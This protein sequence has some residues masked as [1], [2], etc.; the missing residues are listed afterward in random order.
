MITLPFQRKKREKDYRRK[1]KAQRAQVPSFEKEEL[2]KRAKKEVPP[3]EIKVK[4]VGK[5][6]IAYRV[7]KEPVVSEKGTNLAE[8]GKYI[9]KV[10]SQ[11]NKVEIQKAIEDVYKV[12][13]RKV[14][15]VNVH[16]KRKRMGRQE[17]WKQG[18]KKAIVS[19]E[20]GEKMEIVPR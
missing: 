9:F 11:A 6:K 17:G 14:N 10:F 7:L 18:Y 2:V 4:E 16:K 1:A 3:K 5:S 13:V 19:L 20:K 12:K 15:I 8:E